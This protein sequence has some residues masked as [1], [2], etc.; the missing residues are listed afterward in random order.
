MI[1]IPHN[2]ELCKKYLL[3]EISLV[4][5]EI[6]F[7]FS[8]TGL[9]PLQTIT[10]VVADKRRSNLYVVFTII[11]CGANFLCLVGHEAHVKINQ[12]LYT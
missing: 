8:W 9:P 6:S 7:I 3:Q 11:L 10:Q 12:S 5:G 4:I 2:V 1:V